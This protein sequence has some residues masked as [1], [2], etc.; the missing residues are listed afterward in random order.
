MN[1]QKAKNKMT[2][3]RNSRLLKYIGYYGFMSK[4]IFIKHLRQVQYTNVFKYKNLVKISLLFLK[5]SY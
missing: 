4:K 2:N 1:G 5:R 3:K